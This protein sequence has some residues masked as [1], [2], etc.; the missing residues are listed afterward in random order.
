[1]NA[2]RHSHLKWKVC[3]CGYGDYTYLACFL[4]AVETLGGLGVIAGLLTHLATL[5]LLVVLLFATYCTAWQKVCEQKPV[6]MVDCVSCYLWRVEGVYIVIALCILALGPGVY[7][8]DYLLW[9]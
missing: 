3:D 4:A 2:K 1:M 7:S 9:G 8:L 6:D 5:G